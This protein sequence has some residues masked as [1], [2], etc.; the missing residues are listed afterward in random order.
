MPIN[1]ALIMGGIFALM[2]TVAVCIFILPEKKRAGQN[3]FIGFLSDIFN[4]K[5]LWLEKSLRILYVL[6]TLFCISFGFFALFSGHRGYW[7]D[8]H[9]FAGAGLL[10]ML[11]GPVVVRLAFE[12]M[13]MFVLLVKNVMQINNKLSRTEGKEVPK[14][15]NPPIVEETAP[16]VVR[17]EMTQ[18]ETIV[19]PSQEP[20][21]R[22]QAPVAPVQP[23]LPPRYL[24]C[25][26]CGTRYDANKGGCP[27]GH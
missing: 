2:A 9:S 27:F 16:P 21:R 19:P 5:D 12:I 17:N 6:A 7:G 26:T 20:D 23:E 1:V 15:A 8:F 11:L 10:V 14:E 4:F 22:V 24:Y 18:T 13:M 3:K 25:T